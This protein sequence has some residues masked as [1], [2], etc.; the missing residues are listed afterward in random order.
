[1]PEGE[2]GAR[3]GTRTIVGPGARAALPDVLAGFSVEGV[4]LVVGKGSSQRPWRAELEALLGC[5]EVSVHEHAGSAPTEASVAAVVDAACR[6]RA[7]VIVAVGGGSVLDVAKAGSAYLS[8]RDPHARGPLRVVAVP[9]TPGTGA[10]VTPFATVWDFKRT[11]K[12]SITGPGVVPAVAIVDP[13]LTLTLTPEQAVAFA[14]DALTQGAEATWSSQST[15]ES[16]AHGTTAVALVAE[17]CDAVLARPTDVGPRIALSLAGLYSGRAIA[18]SETTACHAISYPLTLRY[19]IPHAHACSLTLGPMLSYNA[20]TTATDCSDP[21]G[22]AHVHAAVRKVVHAL[23]VHDADAA[24]ARV[25]RLRS[26]AG[27]R[28]LGDYSFD[29]GTLA[30][31]AIGYER[32]A[33]NPRRLTKQD[34]IRMLQPASK[35]RA[36]C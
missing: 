1:M 30:T 14:M 4:L 15:V 8:Q 20:R 10:E 29:A 33:H 26:L 22:V 5:F 9:T 16:A 18:I 2:V 27:L 13:E 23:G 25:E 35:A 17:A 11:R 34:L 3:V 32:L 31:D 24:C 36:A 28:G 12:K 6:T 7:E 21:R 19:D